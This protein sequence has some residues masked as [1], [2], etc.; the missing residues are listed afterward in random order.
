MDHKTAER[1]MAV[2]KYLLEEFSPEEQDEFEEHFFCCEE[3][4]RELKLGAAFMAHAKESLRTAAAYAPAPATVKAPK[5]D[6]FRWFSPAFALPAMAFLLGV[7]V[8]QNLVQMPELHRSLDA[9]N[10]PALLPN[11][12]LKSGSSRG[13]AIV[14][15][16]K[17]GEFFE[18]TID[19]PDPANAAHIAD[20]LDASGKKLWSLAVPQDAPKDGLAVK[21]PGD[22][23]AGSYVLVLRN[24]GNSRETGAEVS[25]YVF[26]LKRS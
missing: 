7:V 10:A 15:T 12:D 3:C 2:E 11:A 19:I 21:M 25:R 20:L 23:P 17:A 26:E 5:R 8:F 18:L 24:E 4:A 9:M 22:L 1:T 6:W 13:D 16:A 14:V